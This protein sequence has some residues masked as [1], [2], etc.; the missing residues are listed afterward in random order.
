MEHSSLCYIVGCFLFV[1]L[2]VTCIT[3]PKLLI[4]IF[5]LPTF[6]FGS[7]DF[8]FYIYESVSISF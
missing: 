8:V 5:S 2:I 6:P 4:Y 3:S 7:H 1:L